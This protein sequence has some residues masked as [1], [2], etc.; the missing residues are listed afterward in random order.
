MGINFTS[1][2]GSITVANPITVATDLVGTLTGK[3]GELLQKV[4]TKLG[5][6]GQLFDFS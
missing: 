3:V 6:L 5:Q 2:L 4:G 1:P